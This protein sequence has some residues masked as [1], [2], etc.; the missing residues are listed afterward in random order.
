MSVDLRLTRTHGRETVVM[1]PMRET[2]LVTKT[3]IPDGGMVIWTGKSGLGK[4]K[5]AEWFRDSLDQTFDPSDPLTF[6]ARYLQSGTFSRGDQ[7]KQAIRSLYATVHGAPLTHYGYNRYGP[8][9]LAE[10]VV[11]GLQRKG[12]RLLLID[13]AGCL[14]LNA[15]RGMV[16]VTDIAKDMEW[17]TSLVLIGMDE[18]PET[19]E[20]LPQIESRIHAWCHFEPY[21]FDLTKQFLAALHEHF[22]GLKA[23]NQA[24]EAEAR[25][26][27]ET[28]GGIARP[29]AYFLRQVDDRAQ[30]LGCAIDLDVLIA[31]REMLVSG[32]TGTMA[33]KESYKSKP[34][35][36]KKRA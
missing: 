27:Y 9:E 21:D 36:G 4:T 17:P 35:K 13:E 24:L 15:I 1:A 16:L 8:S 12:I 33:E 31:V 34:A 11:I 10:L 25:Y 28:F 5:T 7:E 26:I 14:S 32:R 2:V 22:S 3:A 18:L 23:G 30:E 29:T 19:V 20:R 6:R